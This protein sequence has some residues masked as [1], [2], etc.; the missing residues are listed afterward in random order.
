MTKFGDFFAENMSFPKQGTFFVKTWEAKEE[1]WTAKQEK[2]CTV[3][4]N[5]LG[6]NA[7]KS[8]KLLA[9]VATILNKIELWFQPTGSAVF[10]SFKGKYHKL[11]LADYTGVIDYAKKL[12]KTKNKLFKLNSSCKIGEPHFIHKFLSELGTGYEIFLA[13]F[14][15]TY[16]LIRISI[17]DGVIVVAAVMFDKAVMAIEKEKQWIKYQEEPKSAYIGTRTKT[18][19][20]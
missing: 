4:R 5:C 17:V 6:F 2:V 10:V 1:F 18:N 11:T 8:V 12:Q 16:S 19:S 13:T 3:I 14:S 7:C 15:Q 20:D 9:T